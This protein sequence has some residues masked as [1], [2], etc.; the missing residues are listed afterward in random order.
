MQ[1]QT[2]P[3]QSFYLKY[4]ELDS[5]R[6]IPKCRAVLEV[7]MKNWKLVQC[8]VIEHDWRVATNY[9]LLW[10]GQEWKL[11]E[12]WKMSLTTGRGLP[13]SQKLTDSHTASLFLLEYS[14]HCL[15]HC[16]SAAP[17]SSPF[18]PLFTP[19][20]L[21]ILSFHCFLTHLGDSSLQIPIY[22]VPPFVSF[23]SSLCFSF[24]YH[25]FSSHIEECSMRRAV[26]LFTLATLLRGEW[27]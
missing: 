19:F 8:T 24:L 26:W 15:T 9:C 5:W 13:I 25:S 3:L 20:L 12:A 27:L 2:D 1:F 14:F 11:T 23:S 18:S 21:P 6:I 10:S 22:F 7:H 4:Q 16:V 17:S